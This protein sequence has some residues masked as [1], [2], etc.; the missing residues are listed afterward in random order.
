MSNLQFGL[1]MFQKTRATIVHALTDLSEAQMLAVPDGFA[2]SIAWNIGHV[3]V[4]QQ[5]MVYGRCGVPLHVDEAAMR[6]LY[7]ANT[8]PAD[9]PAAPD[10]AALVAMLSAHPQRLVDDLDGGLFAG[11]QFEPRT[12]GSGIFMETLE[13]AIH[14]N[15]YHEGMHLGTILSLRDFVSAS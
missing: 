7:W 6:P 12:S 1:Q 15:N 11:K 8:S 13:E 4:I 2:N 5:V 3:I 14:Y 10:V 9:W